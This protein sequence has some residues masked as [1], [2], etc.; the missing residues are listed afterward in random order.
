LRAPAQERISEL[1]EKAAQE[2]WA[3]LAPRLSDAA[4]LAYENKHADAARAWLNLT[5]WSRLLGE[6]EQDFIEYWMRGL[7]EA[8]LA[9]A[10]MPARYALRPKITLGSWMSAS[11][12]A[13]LAG[14][15]AFLNEF[16]SSLSPHD[17]LPGVLSLLEK[18][19][20]ERPEDFKSHPSLAIAL[21]LVHDT[22]PPPDW[23]HAQVSA[24]LLPRKLHDPCQ[25]F[26]YFVDLDRTK[27]SAHRLSSLGAD[28][29]R[30]LVDVAAG[31]DDLLWSRKVITQP[32]AQFARVYGLVRYRMDRARNDTPLWMGSPYSLPKILSEGGICVDQAYFACQVG[33]AR[34]IPT[35]LF[36]GAGLD[37]RHAWFGFLG[38]KR[39]WFLDAGRYAEQRFITGTAIDPQTW[40]PLT[41][42]GL[43]FLAERFQD[44]AAARVSDLHLQFAREYLGRGSFEKALAASRLALRVEPRNLAAYEVTEQALRSQGDTEKALEVLWREAIIAFQRNADLEQRF[45]VRLVDSLR[46]R[47]QT[48]QADFEE[49]RIITKYRDDRADVSIRQ[50]AAILSRSFVQD[51]LPVQIA[52]FNRVLE[53]HGKGAGMTFFDMIVVVFA[54]HLLRLDQRPEALRTLQRAKKT[55]KVEPGSQLDK[56]FE[57]AER[58]IRS[59]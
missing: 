55:L 18:L 12:Q 40:G 37:G 29:L 5:R 53:K 31:F 11:L 23:P 4:L 7:E 14:N 34:G 24:T 16:F 10:N 50:S 22:P 43:R 27:A 26:A 19:R 3:S 25:L 57:K 35:L 36:R 13:E 39:N 41:D 45:S 38:E 33:K 6:R 2:G 56:E 54:E 28:E 9:H 30:F 15:P 21:A 32:L 42:H 59:S 52:T 48:S 1:A 51:P 17:F 58:R 44:Q 8:R 20:R 46:K 47:G 49:K